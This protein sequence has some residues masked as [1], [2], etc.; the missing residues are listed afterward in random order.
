MT[1]NED[2][3]VH[4]DLVQDLLHVLL[5]YWICDHCIKILNLMGGG[6]IS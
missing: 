1:K 2:E 4:G 6:D 3:T 5:L